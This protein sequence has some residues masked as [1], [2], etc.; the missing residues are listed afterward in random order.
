MTELF[1]DSALP[2]RVLQMGPCRQKTGE[3]EAPLVW[4]S[5][6]PHGRTLT[7]LAKTQDPGH[8][9][10]DAS[11]QAVLA[12][13]EVENTVNVPVLNLK[14]GSSLPFPA[15]VDRKSETVAVAGY[16]DR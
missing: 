1:S 4:Q 3:V 12:N 16:P 15:A 8:G 14:E 7:E 9:L 11:N 6:Q 10:V 13:E 2:D 5:S